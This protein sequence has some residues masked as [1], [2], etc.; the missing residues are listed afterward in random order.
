MLKAVSVVLN[1]QIL[2]HSIEKKSAMVATESIQLG[3]FI[4]H[5]LFT[6]MTEE[7]KTVNEP[8]SSLS[9]LILKMTHQ[10]LICEI[11]V[12]DI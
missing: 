9:S 7:I 5:N 1:G 11:S 8:V 3:C 10:L 6:D 4:Y 2:M 12:L